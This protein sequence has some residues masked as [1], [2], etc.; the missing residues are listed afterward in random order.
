MTQKSGLLELK[1]L[2]KKVGPSERLTK[3]N[4]DLGSMDKDT[5]RSLMKVPSVES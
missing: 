3:G 2:A 1:G 5:G 4:N